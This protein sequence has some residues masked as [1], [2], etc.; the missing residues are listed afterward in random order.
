MVPIP[1]WVAV[2]VTVLCLVGTV[3]GLIDMNQGRTEIGV[4]VH[5]AIILFYIVIISF[6]WHLVP[7][8]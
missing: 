2:I 8:S 7:F 4:M 5:L 3:A 6:S 1:L